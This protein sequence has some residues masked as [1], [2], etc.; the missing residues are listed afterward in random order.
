MQRSDR[1]SARDQ[2]C[3]IFSLH[4][5]D[6]A[7][8]NAKKSAH[9]QVSSCTA[10]SAISVWGRTLLLERTR[11]RPGRTAHTYART[12]FAIALLPRR[13]APAVAAIACLEGGAV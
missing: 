12:E 10:G 5:P 4:R 9:G 2:N 7:V 1:T 6:S 11:L 13:R 8:G 3:S